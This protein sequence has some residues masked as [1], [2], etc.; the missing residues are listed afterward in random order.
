MTGPASSGGSSHPPM[1]GRQA[2]DGYELLITSTFQIHNSIAH[3][4][5]ISY[6]Q[7][8]HKADTVQ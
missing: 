3:S 4:V 7:W 5:L 2:G 6:D 8:K 1:L